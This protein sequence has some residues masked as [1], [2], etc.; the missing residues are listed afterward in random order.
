[1][2]QDIDCI[3]VHPSPSQ[4]LIATAQKAAEAPVDFPTVLVWNY[5]TLELIITMGQV[6][7]EENEGAFS[8]NICCLAFSWPDADGNSV[9]AV[10]DGEENPILSIWEGFDARPMP[11]ENKL[12]D[13]VASEAEVLSA[14]FLPESANQ[15]VLTGKGQVSLW[16]FQKEAGEEGGGLEKKQARRV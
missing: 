7:G 8:G 12:H 2:S 5:D 6:G 1:M 15:L 14:H 13:A 4:P 9:L 11:F 10:V 16:S 3:A